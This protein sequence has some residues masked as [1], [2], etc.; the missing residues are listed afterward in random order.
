MKKPESK[1]RSRMRVRV[2][3]TEIQ[4]KLDS[5]FLRQFDENTRGQIEEICRVFAIP[6]RL[7]QVP[8]FSYATAEMLKAEVIR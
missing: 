1:F 2:K 8:P 5:D 7:L 6:P 4:A 3:W